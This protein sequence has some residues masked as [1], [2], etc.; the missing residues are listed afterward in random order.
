[1][2]GTPLEIGVFAMATETSVRISSPRATS[3]D[4]SP[5]KA[6]VIG[7]LLVVAGASAWAQI[8][9]GVI[10]PPEMGFL[11]GAVIGA[12]VTALPWRWAM[13]IPL[14]LSALLTIGPLQTGFP[15]YALSHPT[16]R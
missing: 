6:V 10:I 13:T 15:Q 9:S 11:V 16:D 8:V 2:R 7:A 5:F 4:R 12:G 14:A 3:A 1:M